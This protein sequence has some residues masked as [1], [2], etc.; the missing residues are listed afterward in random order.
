MGWLRWP[1]RKPEPEPTAPWYRDES[2]LD[3]A[4]RER[5]GDT[6]FVKSYGGILRDAHPESVIGLCFQRFDQRWEG[7]EGANEQVAC[8]ALD[9][10]ADMV[11]HP[12]MNPPDWYRDGQFWSWARDAFT[13]D[14]ALIQGADDPYRPTE[15]GHVISAGGDRYFAAQRFRR[16]WQGWTWAVWRLRAKWKQYAARYGDA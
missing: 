6:K 16:R 8:G 4:S 1:W 13:D 5:E 10:E 12:G 14:A 9:I 3:S 11:V 2:F 7:W 15:L